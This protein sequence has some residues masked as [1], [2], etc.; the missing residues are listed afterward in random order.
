MNDRLNLRPIECAVDRGV[1]RKID[2]VKG[3]VRAAFAILYRGKLIALQLNRIIVV[4]IVDADHRTA[5]GQNAPGGMHADKPG[6]ARN[7]K[8]FSARPDF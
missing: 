3:E 6:D 7:H 2:F 1:I 4:Q 8:C 5:A